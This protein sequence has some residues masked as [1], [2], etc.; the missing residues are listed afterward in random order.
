MFI[1]FFS[2]RV[3]GEL[4]RTH[5][6]LSFLHSNGAVCS[7]PVCVCAE[8]VV[9]LCVRCHFSF[10]L[11]CVCSTIVIW[12][13]ALLSFQKSKVIFHCQNKAFSGE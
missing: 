11:L 4:D 13:V 2:F 5:D 3:F 8:S 7:H 6:L 12:C 9:S 10:L 1:F